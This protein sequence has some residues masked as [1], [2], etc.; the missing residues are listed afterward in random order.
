MG[1][2]YVIVNLTKGEYLRPPSAEAKLL[3]F[4][5]MPNGIMAALAVLLASG[6]GRGGGDLRSDASLIGSWAGDR[7]VVA[8]SYGDRELFVAD[9]ARAAGVAITEDVDIEVSL[10]DFARE[11]G[12]DVTGAV[13]DAMLAAG[14][15]L[16]YDGG[17]GGE[18]FAPAD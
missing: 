10:Y 8:G 12:R 6:N 9:F 4:A 3:E 11:H 17:W 7:I 13:R 5:V 2:F 16:R 1:Q 14:E 15:P 18:D